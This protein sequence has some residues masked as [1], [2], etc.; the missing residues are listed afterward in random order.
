MAIIERN[1]KC[2]VDT[3]KEPIW[4]YHPDHLGTSSAITDADGF[5][6]QFF[7]NLPFGETMAEQRG[8]QYYNSP[9]KF[10][11]K[12]LD[13]ET[14]LY[15]YGARYYDPKVSIWLSVD[16]LAEKFPNWSPYS[17]CFNNP[18]NWI[19]PTGMAPDDWV[20]TSSGSMVYDSRVTDQATAT[21][22]YGDGAKY[23]EVG[24]SY[25]ASTGEN[26]QLGDYGFFTSN[27]TVKHS[28]DLAESAITSA[29]VDQ[30][31]SIMA[32][33]LL[34]SGALLAD[35]ATVIGVAD[36]PAI[37]FVLAVAGVVALAAKATYEIQKILKRDPGPQGTQYS[38]R[39][40]TSGAYP[41][42]T[43]PGGTM[44]LNVGDVWKYGETTNPTGRYSP[45]QLSGWKVEQVNEFSGSQ[46][47]I[48]I[49][50]KSKIYNYF[51]I[52]GQLPPGNKIFR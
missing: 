45:S 36:D 47:Q 38:L 44:N 21:E 43:C 8:Q 11:G 29:P 31:G 41:C 2:Y 6:Y 4:W 20:R 3:K 25:T 19:D 52:N 32:G 1:D 26:I 28:A 51:L 48:K 34:I 27:G 24:Y 15:Y 33:G 7:L 18:S 46:M 42:Y 22:L 12:E 35:D 5:A 17:Y 40:T 37:P 16:P 9:Y 30:S 13:E 50:E 39:A 14:G 10:N 23:R 49:A